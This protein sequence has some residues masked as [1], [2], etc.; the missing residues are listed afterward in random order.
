[1]LILKCFLSHEIPFKGYGI[2]LLGLCIRF[3]LFPGVVAHRRG[4]EK[5]PVTQMAV[6]KCAFCEEQ[7]LV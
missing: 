5:V 6:V 2:S 4:K 3:F 7:T 1:M